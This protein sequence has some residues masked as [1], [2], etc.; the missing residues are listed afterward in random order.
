MEIMKVKDYK[1]FA[2]TLAKASGC[3]VIIKLM[4]GKDHVHYQLEKTGISLGVLCINQGDVSFAPFVTHSTVAD[5]Q[6]IN[7]RFFPFIDDFVDLM[8]TFKQIFVE[9][10]KTA[11]DYEEGE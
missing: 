3:K 1:S 4:P 8:R 7:I 11:Y 9:S 2:D 5:S 10:D 6:F